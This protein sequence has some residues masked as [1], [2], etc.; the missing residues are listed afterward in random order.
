MLCNHF[1]H[2]IR[3][4]LTSAVGSTA[5]KALFPRSCAEWGETLEE[6]HINQN[7]DSESRKFANLACN[8]KEAWL[9]HTNLC[10]YVL[11]GSSAV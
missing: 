9:W 10:V 11:A 6:S 3:A 2:L 4:P 1:V 8:H 5:L 7:I